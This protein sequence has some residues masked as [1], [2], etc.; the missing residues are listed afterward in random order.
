MPRPF[1]TLEAMLAPAALRDLLGREVGEVRLDSFEPAAWSSTES[2]FLGVYLD[3]EREPSLVVKRM[4]SVRDWI[5]L[6][7]EDELGRC[8]TQW[9]RGLLG[10][11]P[12]EVDPAVVACTRNEVGPAILMRNVERDLLPERK[13]FGERDHDAVLDAMAALHAKF[14]LDPALEDA[15]LGLCTPANLFTHTSAAKAERIAAK[16][17]SGVLEFILKGWALVP[18]VLDEDVVELLHALLRDPSP[19]CAALEAFEWTLVHG[20]LRTANIG[21]RWEGDAPTLIA[22]DMARAVRTA[23]AV[24]LAWHLATTSRELPVPKEHA[25]ATYRRHIERR[26]GRRFDD[27]AWARQVELCLLAGLMMI[28]P[29]NTAMAMLHENPENPENPEDRELFRRN[30]A[31]FS[32]R[33]REGARHLAPRPG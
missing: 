11:F 5:V 21:L 23:P 2:E 3:G 27:A 25:I 16:H 15:E 6:G 31:W 22:L 8:V 32:E 14:W 10:R 4:D 29:I 33:A 1:D 17:P 18:E 19:L 9:S 30:L 12:P 7:T 24:D 28:A 13:P 20:D 26:L